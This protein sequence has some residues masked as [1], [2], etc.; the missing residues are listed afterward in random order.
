MR[1]REIHH[2]MRGWPRKEKRVAWLV[3]RAHGRR[4]PEFIV[5]SGRGRCSFHVRNRGPIQATP[6][7]KVTSKLGRTIMTGACSTGAVEPAR[8][9]FQRRGDEQ[10]LKEHRGWRD[11]ECV[12]ACPF[13]SRFYR[14]VCSS[15]RPPAL[16]KVECLSFQFH[17]LRRCL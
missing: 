10:V 3:L 2:P 13:Q 14:S 15:D 6:K 9:P 5:F 12:G 7:G 17:K 11:G 8:V 4:T 16:D 1:G